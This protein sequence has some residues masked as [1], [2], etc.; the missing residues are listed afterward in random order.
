ML[1]KILATEACSANQQSSIT[2]SG[3]NG[4][5]PSTPGW[6][7]VNAICRWTITA[8]VGKVLRIN[9]TAVFPKPCG[10]EYLRIHD[11]PSEASVKI[12][13]FDCNSSVVNTGAY[14]YS[15]G[16]SLW[17]E[18]KTG[19]KAN[20]T[21]IN[22]F[23]QA[24]DKQGCS[25]NTT[26]DAPASPKKD[27]FSSP[28]YPDGYPMN[29]TCGWYIK[30]PEN[31]IVRL[32]VTKQLNNV[33]PSKISLEAYDVDGAEYTAIVSARR[34]RP[35]AP[36]E[37][38]SKS[39]FVYVLFKTDNEVDGYLERGISVEYA[40][41]R[42]ARSCSFD[43]SYDENM[44]IVLREPSGVIISP[45]YPRGYNDSLINECHWKIIAP[46]GKVVRVEF[47]SFHL[48]KYDNVMITDTING[49]N[50]RNIIRF[51]KQLSFTFFSTGHELK[52]EAKSYAGTYGPGFIA[53]YTSVSSVLS[54]T[55][56]PKENSTVQMS[57][58]GRSF[59]TP[60]FPGNPGIG[61]CSW[62]ITVPR[63]KFVK[64]TFWRIFERCNR[65]FVE[66]YD[67]TNS[68]RVHLGKF[69]DN[70]RE[71]VIYS[72]GNNLLVKYSSL[73]VASSGGFFATSESMKAVP[74]KYACHKM[75]YDFM[76]IKLN[77]TQGEFAS[78]DY[79]LQY[80]NNA[81]CLWAIESPAEF[82][83]Q[84]T[85]HSFDLQQSED[86][87]ADYVEIKQ[88]K[89]ESRAELIGRYCGSSLPPVI[90]SNHSKVFVAFVTD[91]SGS[92]PGFHATYKV[93]PNPAMGLCKNRGK[94]NVIPL[95]G[96]TGELF[97]PLFPRDYPHSIMCTWVI[98]VPEGHFVK[99]RIKSFKLS[100]ICYDLGPTLDI[101]DG[102]SSSS[103]RLKSFCGQRFEPSVF[104]S[105]RHLWVRFDIP[106]DDAIYDYGF[107]AVFEAVKQ[108][109][110]PFACTADN[111][112][113]VLESKTGSLASYNY[114]LPYDD[115]IECIWRFQFDTDY[116]IKLSFDFFNLSHSTDCSED[117]V[118]VRD[119]ASGT[120]ELLGKFCG[121]NKP[122]PI[123]SDSWD[124]YVAFK[125]SGKTKY[126]GF[127]ASYE[128][129]RTTA[130]ILKI[131]GICV[132]TVIAVFALIGVCYI[133]YRKTRG[134]AN[135][136]VEND[137]ADSMPLQEQS[138]KF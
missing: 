125:S 30:A 116:K 127:K 118:E 89:Y 60:G 102:Q 92:Y 115:K 136:T 36:V 65:N 81:K 2:L 103:N 41:V 109:P 110:A 137:D 46:K 11:G 14:I 129:K 112:L 75:K 4:T 59:S 40:A 21:F 9:I 122:V 62:N 47:P 18:V 66:V 90:L 91:I 105:G 48:A 107:Y 61:T 53:N 20:S 39:R 3:T 120:G 134:Q 63:G 31:H 93:L 10:D 28:Y 128:T 77:G 69:C 132:G 70:H 45:G 50:A 24:Q 138:T 38:Y 119:D 29:T 33:D 37:V 106:E 98:T 104:S 86:C 55:C 97:S 113:F 35:I 58:D 108:L 23:Y 49:L 54:G 82:I 124:M 100:S 5:I 19:V 80:P 7:P 79:P 88:G 15:S 52:L 16:H 57:G 76:R 8:P 96:K 114:P 32:H 121:S 51:G 87:Q 67:V 126:P 99:L 22:L 130:A 123:T 13:K 94:N 83:I 27:S 64:L 131:V 17:L 25:L 73:S 78:Y 6:L 135:A 74:A 43:N 72:K 1:F 26:L 84:L 117:Y 95:T 44:N 101:R 111:H 85:F 12:V 42:T 68:T 56:I 133:T 71:Q 34:L